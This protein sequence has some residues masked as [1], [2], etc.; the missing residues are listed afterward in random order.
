MRN[1]DEYRYFLRHLLSTEGCFDGVYTLTN[2]QVEELSLMI[3]DASKT[4][5]DEIAV[6]DY[7]GLDCQRVPAIETAKKLGLSGP[8]VNQIRHRTERELKKALLRQKDFVVQ[9]SIQGEL[10]RK[11]D[12][13]N[14]MLK[15]EIFRIQGYPFILLD[16]INMSV[17]ARYVIGKLKV[18]TVKELS[19]VVEGNIR[20]CRSAGE[21]T[22]LELRGILEKYNLRF[23]DPKADTLGDLAFSGRNDWTKDVSINILKLSSRTLHCLERGGVVNIL[24]LLNRTAED[25]MDLRNFGKICLK[26]VKKKLSFHGLALVE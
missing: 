7:Y 12:F 26:E 4:K 19:L 22:V 14:K 13:E 17:K 10:I 15:E 23:A 8:R 24:D 5:K 1:K 25:L 6:K 9:F 2:E 11:L 20:C 21:T 18:R 16:D 3:K